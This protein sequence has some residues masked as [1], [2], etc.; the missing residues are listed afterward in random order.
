MITCT[1]STRLTPRARHALAVA[2]TLLCGLGSAA[3]A[4]ASNVCISMSGS[5]GLIAGVQLALKWD[6]ACMS[7]DAGSGVSARC[8]ADPATGK[9]VHTSLKAGPGNM[10]ALF[11]SMSDTSPIPDGD[12]FCCSFTRASTGGNPCCG[13]SMGKIIGSD[14]AGTATGTF[15]L[16]A[17]VDGQVCGSQGGTGGSGQQQPQGVGAPGGGGIVAPPVVSAPGANAPAGGGGGGAPQ[18]APAGGSGQPASGEK[19]AMG[20]QPVGGGLPAGMPGKPEGQE[21]P[22][23]MDQVQRALDQLRGAPTAVAEALTPRPVSTPRPAAMAGTPTVKAPGT[24]T[25]AAKKSA[26]TQATPGAKTTPA[27]PNATPKATPDHSKD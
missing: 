22:A 5:G 15:S 1:P 10:T 18:A 23:G 3:P 9:D 27:T 13:L 2:T 11:F 17:S 21:A 26:E 8:T 7:A 19:P 20:G 6:S 25:A 4:A 14:S 24:P 12:L 16:T